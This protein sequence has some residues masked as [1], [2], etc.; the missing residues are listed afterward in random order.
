MA[1]PAA[2]TL[3]EDGSLSIQLG[4]TDADSDPLTFEL[5]ELPLHGTLSNFEAATGRV[6]YRPD[7]N[8]H[9]TDSLRFRV[10]DGKL[11]VGEALVS[12]TVTRSM[13]VRQA[14]HRR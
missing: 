1:T 12:I 10:S 8:Y 5:I 11:G 9:G 2:V 7:A 3:A 6:T 14:M 13:T 4:A